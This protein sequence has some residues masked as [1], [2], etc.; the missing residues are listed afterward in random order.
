M[1]EGDLIRSQAGAAGQLTAARQV[2]AS[3]N[4]LLK[5]GSLKICPTFFGRLRRVTQIST[6][7]GL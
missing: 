6:T 3:T 2:Q 5:R 7:D 4:A 1:H